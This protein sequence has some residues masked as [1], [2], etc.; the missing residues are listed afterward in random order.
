MFLIEFSSLS[1]KAIIQLASEKL[2]A[3]TQDWEKS[4]WQFVSDWFNP[5][6]S[7]IKI[8]TS[9][10][11]GA[12]K[13]IE[14]SK[15]AML[16]SARIT[17]QALQLQKR[18]T[19]L[20]CLPSN[21]IG[22]MMMLVRSIECKMD[23]YCIKPNTTPLNDLSDEIKFDFAAFTPMQLHSAIKN[24]DHFKRAE[25]IDKIILG[26]ENINAE[27]LQI[28]KRLANKVYSTFGMTETISHIALKKLNGLNADKHY[29][30]LDGIKIFSSKNNCLVIEAP[31]LN[32]PH[33]ITNDVVRIISE[34]EFDWLGRIDNVINSGGVKIHPEEIEQALQGHIQ[35]AFFVGA[36]ANEKTGEQLVLAIEMNTPNEKDKEELKEAFNSLAKLHRPKVVLLFNQFIRTT[37]GKIK[38]KESLQS[39]FESIEL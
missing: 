15:Q 4:I 19:A 17:C 37:N 26:G 36:I 7:I 24:Y 9:G 6:V 10:S 18:N 21:K 38:R 34:K 29:K 28:I 2:K 30:A 23:L 32:Q 11:T 13:Q 27:L 31:V 1:N 14:H 8:F 3:D 25:Q 33:L 5:S 39:S 20:L 22:G 12:P 35:P 16:N